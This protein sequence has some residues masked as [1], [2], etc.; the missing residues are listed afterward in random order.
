MITV[1]KVEV[2]DG[3]DDE[4]DNK[5]EKGDNKNDGGDKRVKVGDNKNEMDG[6]DMPQF[7]DGE[8]GEDF[9]SFEVSKFELFHFIYKSKKYIKLMVLV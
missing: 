4:S 1:F 5:D 2:C 7:L 6:D 3:K 9:T 8:G